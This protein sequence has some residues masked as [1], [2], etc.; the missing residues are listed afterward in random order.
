MI[1]VFTC[2]IKQWAAVRTYRSEIKVPPH[3]T[4]NK[5][6][7]VKIFW[8]FSIMPI[9]LNLKWGWFHF[10]D[11]NCPRP[12]SNFGFLSI[13]NTWLV[14]DSTNRSNG[15]G[16]SGCRGDWWRCYRCLSHRRRWNPISWMV[17]LSSWMS[18]LFYSEYFKTILLVTTHCE[19]QS[20][21]ATRLFNSLF[22]IIY[23]D[24]CYPSL[25]V[26]IG[27]FNIWKLFQNYII[28]HIG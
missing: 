4:W 21:F 3:V 7:F 20:I 11:N 25:K 6:K 26:K 10:S 5:K 12:V 28:L 16:W 23:Y 24:I 17:Y 9:K 14:I 13:H 22:Q 2:P 15:L 27:A 1:V 19:I 8:F 18:L